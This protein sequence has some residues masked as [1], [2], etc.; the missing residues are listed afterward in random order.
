ADRVD[1][2]DAGGA[3]ARPGTGDA[4]LAGVGARLDGARLAGIAHAGF[5]GQADA[6]DGVVGRGV[7][8]VAD[9]ARVAG[10]GG[11]AGVAAP[12]VGP[13]AAAVGAALREGAEEVGRL[14]ARE[15][16][17]DAR[18]ARDLVEEV[19][20][21]GHRQRVGRDRPGRVLAE[22]V[23][24]GDRARLVAALAGGVV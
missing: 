10:P 5:R 2:A 23:E 11:E 4:V 13:V 17:H 24:A 9:E 3:G 1:V 15:G 8:G 20:R 21:H 16:V 19:A 14:A 22:E 18:P 12:A 7:V 6:H